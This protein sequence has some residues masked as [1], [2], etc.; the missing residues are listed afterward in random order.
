MAKLTGEAR[1]KLSSKSFALPGRGKGK[2]GKGAGSYPIPDR[3]HGA[4]AL[5]RVSQ[6]GTP[7]EKRIVRAKVH[8]KWPD[9]GKKQLG[10]TIGKPPAVR[11]PRAPGLIGA[12]RPVRSVRP[13]GPRVPGRLS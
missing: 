12:P 2:G 7:E 6:H 4:N 8:A 9:M 13:I 11:M 10:G 5:S 1:Q 3:S